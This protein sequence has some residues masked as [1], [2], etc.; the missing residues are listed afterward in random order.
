[1]WQTITALADSR[2]RLISFGATVIYCDA[3]NVCSVYYAP[4]AAGYVDAGAAT[5]VAHG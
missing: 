3:A 1:M 5:V 4:D 2:G